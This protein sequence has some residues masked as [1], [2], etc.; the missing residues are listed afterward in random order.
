MHRVVLRIVQLASPPALALF[1][2]GG[3]GCNQDPGADNGKGLY[4]PAPCPECPSSNYPAGPIGFSLGAVIPDAS[5][6]GFANAQVDAS[7]LQTIRLSDFYNPHARDASYAPSD[8]T[9]DDRLFAPDSQYGAGAKKPTALLIDISSGWCGP[10]KEEA[11]SVLPGKYAKY[12]PCGGEFLVQLIDGPSVNTPA[13][14]ENLVSWTTA[15][16]VDYPAT[17]DSGGQLQDFYPTHS[18]PDVAVIDTTTMTIAAVVNGLPD[19]GF[20]SA[21]ESLLDKACLAGK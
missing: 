19:D 4:E 10:C 20:W 21:Y 2:L 16:K 15:F 13:T 18:Y 12:H 9:Q 5:F 1:A 6:K 8:P 3:V 7:Q 14:Q 11:K 17:F